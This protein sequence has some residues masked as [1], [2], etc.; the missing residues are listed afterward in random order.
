VVIPVAVVDRVA[1]SIV[2]IV[3]MVPMRDGDVAAVGPV[4]V[5]MPLVDRMLNSSALVHVVFVYAMDVVVVDIVDMVPMRERD[6]STSLT[7]DVRM[8]GVTAVLGCGGHHPAP[9]H[10]RVAPA[11]G[12]VIGARP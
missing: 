5:L 11:T 7:V 6:V 12:A 2:D 9:C 1:M 10:V 3:H 4:A 8:V